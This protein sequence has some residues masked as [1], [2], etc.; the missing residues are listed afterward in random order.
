MPWLAKDWEKSIASS[1]AWIN[2][3]HIDSQRGARKVLPALNEFR[4]RL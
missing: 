1:E 2:I 4:V 3:A